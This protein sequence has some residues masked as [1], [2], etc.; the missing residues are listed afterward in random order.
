MKTVIAFVS[1]ETQFAPCGGIAAVMASLPGHVQKAAGRPTI[2]LTPFHRN[3]EKT[4]SRENDMLEVGRVE[5]PFEKK[6]VAVGLYR[7]DQSWPWYFLKPE[8]PQFFGGQRHPYDLDAGGLVRDALFFCSA[9]AR[10][11][12][13]A[14]A[15]AD[16]RLLLQDWE[17]AAT[18]LALAD[19]SGR[20]R[21]F[22]TIHNS[23]DATVSDDDLRRA[24]IEPTPFHGG[25]VLQRAL[26]YVSKT[27]FTV[28]AQFAQDL[29]EDFLQA[30]IMAPHLKSLL[31]PRLVG[32]DN[33]IFA[34]LALS[35]ELIA[36]MIRGD[37]K[38]LQKWKAQKRA[39]AFSAFDGY[40]STNDRPLW[41]NL[42]LFK[43]D[44]APWF[45][46]AG[47]DDPRQ[48]GY[49]VAAAAIERFLSEAG[50]ARFIFFPIPG[51]EG[52]Q[53]LMFLKK[54]ADRFPESVIVLP[55]LFREGFFATLQG[56][57]YGIMPSLYEPFG[58]ANEFYLNGTVGIGRAT[59][60]IIQQIVPLR[61]AASYSKAVDVRAEQWH[62]LSVHPTG[63]L[64]R[65]PDDIGSAMDDWNH[66]NAGGYSTK[67]SGPN[68][69]EE[70]LKYR[71]FRTMADELLNALR[72]GVRVYEET[73]RL[74]HEML[75][76]G[77][78]YVLRTF[79]WER[80]AHQYVRHI[81]L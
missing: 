67:V 59:G 57:T 5:V 32:I 47:R 21:C 41:G 78:R 12:S 54:L 45:V 31:K 80:A 28:S 73:P 22:L 25:T 14:D 70:R 61:S 62:P 58:M 35:E 1:Y 11:L 37:S 8:D 79:S 72:D 13:V 23:Y 42:A 50:A 20:Y 46:M 71:L 48:K 26:P 29:T 4:L 43:R 51:D 55:V 17:T 15:D 74:Y 64:Y 76:E 81:E 2:V 69:V 24:G 40:V 18:A 9:V 27:V 10:V 52:I 3:I 65:E 49:D 38:P 6:K 53:G 19:N 33:G 44:G 39:E 68:R 36:K 30:K 75:A 66:I 56:A 77:I 7:V 34:R 60:G 16:W 63:I